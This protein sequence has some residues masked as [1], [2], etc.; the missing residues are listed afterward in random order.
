MEQD[1]QSTGCPRNWRQAAMDRGNWRTTLCRPC[2]R[3]Y[4]HLTQKFTN[5]SI[6]YITDEDLTTVGITEMGP[7]LIV[8][9]VI[10]KLIMTYKSEEPTAEPSQSSNQSSFSSIRD[11]L[12][13]NKKTMKI[14]YCKLNAKLIH[15]HK[16][17][18]LITR[19]VCAGMVSHLL[20]NK[21]Y[22]SFETFPILQET[23]V[24]DSSPD[25][26][27]FFW[28]NGGRGPNFEHTGLIQSHIRKTCRNLAPEERKLVHKAKKNGES[29]RFHGSC[30]NSSRLRA[31][32]RYLKISAR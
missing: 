18:L 24:A 5:E 15:T 17:L 13:G 21:K 7:R 14:L 29:A 19:V 3:T 12:K 28:K 1:L 22:P 4:G 8:K 11:A 10:A 9:S 20:K 25:Y 6:M 23:K 2:L 32:T 31:K 26:S 30:S 16:E 27:M